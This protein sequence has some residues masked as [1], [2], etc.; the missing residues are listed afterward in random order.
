MTTE[1]FRGFANAIL[2]IYSRGV[3]GVSGW[4]SQ[5]HLPY[6]MPRGGRFRKYWACGGWCQ[7]CPGWSRSSTN[8]DSGR[9]GLRL[10]RV[11]GWL[12]QCFCRGSPGKRVQE[13]PERPPDNGVGQRWISLLGLYWTAPFPNLWSEIAGFTF[14]FFCNFIFNWKIIT[15]LWWFLPCITMTQP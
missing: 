2:I 12:P 10:P 8:A 4:S 15:I 6:V 3:P 7:H 9:S 11:W 13:F 1:C 14:Y 5:V